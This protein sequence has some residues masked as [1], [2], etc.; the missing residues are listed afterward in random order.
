MLRDLLLFQIKLEIFFFFK[1]KSTDFLK[2]YHVN[3][4]KSFYR[5]LAACILASRPLAHHLYSVVS[6]P[7]CCDKHSDPGSETNLQ[8]PEK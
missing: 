5:L 2:K 1:V 7:Q 3:Q 4:T 8:N 6:L